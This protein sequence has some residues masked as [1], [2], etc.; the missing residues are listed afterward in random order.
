MSL[1]DFNIKALPIEAQITYLQQLA[2]PEL[3]RMCMVNKYYSDLINSDYVITLLAYKFGV[4]KRIN[5][6]EDLISD[7]LASL[8]PK[9]VYKFYL[10]Y[11]DLRQYMKDARLAV[12][13]MLACPRIDCVDTFE[14]IITILQ[15]D[16][17]NLG[18]SLDQDINVLDKMYEIPVKFYKNVQR[19]TLMIGIAR[20]MWHPKYH[21]T[22][23]FKPYDYLSRQSLLYIL[24]KL[25]L[26]KPYMTIVDLQEMT[27]HINIVFK[28]IETELKKRTNGVIP[29]TEFNSLSI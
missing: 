14:K 23:I 21:M 5:K 3:A 6:F 2:M 11:E 8:N 28:M 25:E 13:F 19:D 9:A 27:S 29:T 17:K 10:E 16:A 4:N 18:Y 15:D 26:V 24:G 12:K 7:I 1:H 20:T 22:C